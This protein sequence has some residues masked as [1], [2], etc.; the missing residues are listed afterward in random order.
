VIPIP[1]MDAKSKV[2]NDTNKEIA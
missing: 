1:E 2:N